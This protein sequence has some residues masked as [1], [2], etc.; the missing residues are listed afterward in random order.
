[1]YLDVVGRVPREDEARRFLVDTGH[2]KRA[3][4]V[5]ELLAS[6]AFAEHWGDVYADLLIGVDPGPERRVHGS[7]QAWL[8]EQ[9]AAGRPYDELV[10][11]LLTAGADEASVDDPRAAGYLFA[12]GRQ[13]RL[14]ALTGETARLFL[15]VQLACAQCHDHPY[16]ERYTQREFYGM[17]A[18]FARTRVRRGAGGPGTIRI[19]D[20]PRGE[21][22]IPTA[23]GEPGEQVSPRFLGAPLEP[24]G[25]ESR[26]EAFVRAMRASPLLAEA[27]VNRTW[28]QLFGRGVVEPYDDLG[29]EGDARPPVL[30]Q[31]AGEFRE[32]GY[33]MRA[34]IRRIV[35]S[36]AYQ[37]A[38]TGAA[39]GPDAI[40]AAERAFAR[41]AV[42][43]LSSRQLFTSLIVAAGLGDSDRAAARRLVEQRREQALREYLFLFNDD[44]M[45]AIDSF[46][47]NVPQA[48]L[49]LNGQLTNRGVTIG[50][51]G[52]VKRA[53]DGYA[54]AR[55]DEDARV[56]GLA[57]LYLAA[58][59]RPPSD[60]ER[61]GTRATSSAPATR[62][63]PTRTCCSR[64]CSRASS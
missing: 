37:R 55:D 5:D 58:Y 22:F 14:E 4:V 35:L 3:R 32:S 64:C 56:N 38:S 50:A 21:A 44:E 17:A 15:G 61:E 40:A 47:G 10:A 34:L 45:S 52:T 31:L 2:D 41:A 57:R 48:L 60:A 16:D 33:D 11:D 43:P 9:F 28:W 42:R 20:R 25:D 63:R 54:R 24:E 12:K 8:S 26:R 30:Q 39:E 18:Y 49:L 46:D 27:A 29:G 36:R 19:V 59:G 7:T 53:L 62:R 1:M 6:D 51:G 13:G 23:E